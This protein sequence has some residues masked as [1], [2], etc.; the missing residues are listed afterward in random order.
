M[1]GL[2]QAQLSTVVSRQPPHI[3]V[4]VC[5]AQSKRSC[6]A[7][8]RQ[9]VLSVARHSGAER[10]KHEEP[11][12]PATRAEL[13]SASETHVRRYSCLM[14]SLSAAPWCHPN[15]LQCATKL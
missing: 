9:H 3:C 5:A 7:A 8:A 1:L 4:L 2:A 14:Y 11:T 13:H 12:P 15:W 10:T 6:H